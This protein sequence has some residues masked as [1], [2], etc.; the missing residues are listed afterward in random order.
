MTILSDNYL[1]DSHSEN[2][3]NIPFSPSLGCPGQ[4]NSTSINYILRKAFETLA[5]MEAIQ[6]EVLSLDLSSI[7]IAT[8]PARP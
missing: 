6:A 4:P 3:L 7:D 5:A 2:Y 8:Y 1:T